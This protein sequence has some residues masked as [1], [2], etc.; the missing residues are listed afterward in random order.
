VATT[1]RTDE[2]DDRALLEDDLVPLGEFAAGLVSLDPVVSDASCAFVI[3]RLALDQPIELEVRTD[4]DG[5]VSVHTAP[6]TQHVD[7]A[8]WPVLH[9]LRLTYVR[10]D[11]GAK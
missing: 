7:T 2:Q 10:N 5:A 1:G 3:E 4:D 8:F 6:P 9:R 11:D